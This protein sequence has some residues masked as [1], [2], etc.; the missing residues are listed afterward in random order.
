MFE[1]APYLNC[2]R[3]GLTIRPTVAVEHCPRC[4]ALRRTAVAMFASALPADELYGERPPTAGD[5]QTEGA[6]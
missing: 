6:A 5:E 4:L 2:P 3:C 1:S